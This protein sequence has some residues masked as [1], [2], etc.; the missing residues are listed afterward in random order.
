MTRP[1]ALL[2]AAILVIGTGCAAAPNQGAGI[3]LAMARV[4]RASAPPEDAAP[5]A[6]AIDA[7]GFDLYRAVAPADGNAV[8]SPA[9]VA[10]ALAMARA[11]AQG[12]TATQ[13]D[14][15]LRAVGAPASTSGLVAL[16]AALAARSGTFADAQGTSR[17]VTLRIANAPF[18]QRD[19]QLEPAFLDAL[20]SR[21]GAGLRLVD[22]RAD[23]EAARRL[24]DGWVKEQTS[25][26]IPELLAPGAFDSLTRLVLV[27][28]IYLKAP[29][30]LPFDPT[31]TTP[32]PFTRSDGSTI[33]VPTMHLVDALR[34]GSG[35]GWQAVELPYV[36]GSLALDLI[37]PADIAAFRAGLD[38][39]QLSTITAA[40][41]D[42][43]VDLHLPRFDIVTRV[44]LAT[45]LAGMGMPLAFDP[46]QADF[47]GITPDERLFISSVAHQ[48]TISV[49]EA[50]TEASAATAVVMRATAMPAEAVAL[51]LN[52]PFVFA[53]R[54]LPTGAV[55]FLGQVADPAVG[56]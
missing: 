29:W 39:G 1:L 10:I 36:G 45:V 50:G 13:M 20:A 26:R 14:A 52:R 22:Y 24:I 56:A 5:A 47:A 11:G 6:A 40:L 31:A 17:P 32:R 27:N 18:A 33:S 41:G 37:L 48:A 8:V 23:P 51:D 21:F 35:P 3:E 55:L 34:H 16:D 19:M 38:A 28:A 9:S 2:L 49:D 44:D 54:D 30:A 12:E 53:L 25:G 46:Q 7:F 15:V 42:R 43:Q 4:P